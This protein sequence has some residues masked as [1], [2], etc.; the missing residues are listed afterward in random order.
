MSSLILIILTFNT[1]LIIKIKNEI[2]NKFNLDDAIK[3]KIN[4]KN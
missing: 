3:E 2:E 1:V 4:F